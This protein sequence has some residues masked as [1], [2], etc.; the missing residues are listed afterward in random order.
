[1]N[2]CCPLL[3]HFLEDPRLD[4]NY[5]EILRRYYIHVSGGSATQALFFCPWCGKKFPEDL[6]DE[7]HEILWDI[8]GEDADLD[9]ID[10]PD[11][12]KGALWWKNRGL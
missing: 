9:E 12:F 3:T 7:Y 2:H 4:I 5:N 11:E 8:F 6:V 1:M 10:L